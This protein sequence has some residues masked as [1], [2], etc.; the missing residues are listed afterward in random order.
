PRVSLGL[1]QRAAAPTTT[2]AGF[3]SEVELGG[4]GRIKDDARIAFRF[5][6]VDEPPG[7]PK[8]ERHWKGATFD[9]FDGVAWKDL[10][11][12]A[13]PL[14]QGPYRWYELQPPRSRHTELYEVEL[15]ADDLGDTIFVTGDTQAIRFMRKR[16]ESRWAPVGP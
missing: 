1:W 6:R 11:V 12:P 5:R 8:F 9:H 16:G 7:T 4:H 15:E 10:S 13:R 14:T 3:S 2:R